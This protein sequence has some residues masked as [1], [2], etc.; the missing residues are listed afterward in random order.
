M[1]AALYW[2]FTNVI[3]RACWF[4]IPNLLYCSLLDSKFFC[5]TSL[6]LLFQKWEGW[7]GLVLQSFLSAFQ[8][9]N[10]LFKAELG[11]TATCFAQRPGRRRRTTFPLT[12]GIYCS[13]TS[14]GKSLFSAE[15]QIRS[16]RISDSLLA[17]CPFRFCA[18]AHLKNGMY[19]NNILKFGKMILCNA[20]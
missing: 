20:F 12:W 10:H 5:R 6:S 14:A 18:T 4:F 19:F 15:W 16:T 17:R 9:L 13:P 11:G 2:P 8:L 3:S 7:R 1:H